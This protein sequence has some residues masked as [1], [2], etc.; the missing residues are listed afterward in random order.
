[1]SPHISTDLETRVWNYIDH[2]LNTRRSEFDN[3]PI[4]PYAQRYRDSIRVKRAETTLY[5]VLEWGMRN[6][7]DSDVCWVYAFER[8][9]VPSAIVCENMCDGFADQYYKNG[10][11]ILLDHPTN[12]EPI[13]GV[14]TGFGDGV[15]LIIQNTNILQTHRHQLFKTAYYSGW[16]D[17]QKRE[18]VD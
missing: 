17:E 5:E 11:T 18:L 10:A 2:K 1:M 14:Y 13:N 4:C 7:K 3:L 8:T 6:F 12:I 9:Q 15:L 16:T